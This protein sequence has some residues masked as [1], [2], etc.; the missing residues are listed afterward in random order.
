MGWGVREE[1]PGLSSP[2]T[3]CGGCIWTA[4]GVTVQGQS[5]VSTRPVPTPA[6]PPPALLPLLSLGDALQPGAGRRLQRKGSMC[7]HLGTDL[8]LKVREKWAFPCQA[9][10]F[11]L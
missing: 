1:S 10:R 11:G 2:Q 5:H 9:G 7:P 6:G 8:L 3:P 4:P